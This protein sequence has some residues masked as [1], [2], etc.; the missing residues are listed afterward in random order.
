M[1]GRLIKFQAVLVLGSLMASFYIAPEIGHALACGGAIAL[2]N[3]LLLVWRARRGEH[4]AALSA[5]WALRQAYRSVIERY[6]WLMLLFAVVYKFSALPPMWVLIG[7]I[8][9]QAGWVLAAF[10]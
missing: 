1:Y 5:G 7:F 2:F 10:L 4:L 9:G 8:A 6:L 3:T